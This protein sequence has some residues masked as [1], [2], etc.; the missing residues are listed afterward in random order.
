MITAKAQL[1]PR[2]QTGL[3]LART[4][5]AFP[6]DVVQPDAFG[7]DEGPQ[8]HKQTPATAGRRAAEGSEVTAGFFGH[9]CVSVEA[10]VRAKQVQ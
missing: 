2:Q 10:S 4:T 3:T 1:V 9:D 5:P 6:A 8:N 7:P